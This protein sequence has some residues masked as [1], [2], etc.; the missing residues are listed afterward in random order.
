MGE[1]ADMQVRHSE[2]VAV[3]IPVLALRPT[4]HVRSVTI[5]N[6]CTRS[7][8]SFTTLSRRAWFELLTA[9]QGPKRCGEPDKPKPRLD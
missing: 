1:V 5:P 7:R 8:T 3:G 6:R 4:N 9:I 2:A